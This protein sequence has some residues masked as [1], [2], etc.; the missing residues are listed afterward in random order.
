[1]AGVINITLIPLA[2][3]A[4]GEAA[5]IR[6][7]AT[8]AVVAMASKTLGLP[9]EGLIA[10]DAL[11]DEDFDHR[12]HSWHEVTGATADVYE[13]MMDGTLADNRFVA[14]YGAVDWTDYPSVS[15]LRFTI[16]GSQR[17]VWNLENLYSNGGPRVGLTAG[18]ILIPQNT[19]Y[20]VARYVEHETVTAFIVLKCV[21]VEPVGKLVSP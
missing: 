12:S 21:V 15:A 6:Q 3:L 1:M 2:E 17:V 19:P 10:R 14:I 13:T 16:G 5:N 4:S 18:P 8:N 11:P 9:P 7:A 20:T